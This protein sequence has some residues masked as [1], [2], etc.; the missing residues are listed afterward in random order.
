MELIEGEIIVMPLIGPGH[1]WDMDI[2]SNYFARSS[3]GRF[4]VR[5]QNP[6]HLDDARSDF[7]RQTGED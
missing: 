7:N 4:I 1:A 6:M 2:I 5:T 3:E